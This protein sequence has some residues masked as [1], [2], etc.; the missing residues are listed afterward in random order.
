MLL[1]LL[2]TDCRSGPAHASEW[3][4]LF[5]GKDLSGWT[6]KI[7]GFDFGDNHQDTYRVENGVIRVATNN[8][9]NVYA[10]DTKTKQVR[11]VTNHE[12]FPV[13]A[14]SAGGGKIVYEQAGYLHL[15]DPASGSAKVLAANWKLKAA[16]SLAA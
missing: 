4:A 6:P 15:L 5:N 13:L 11:R 10:F 9:F 12:D 14:A 3:T 7:K 16:S 8:P 1:F 2:T